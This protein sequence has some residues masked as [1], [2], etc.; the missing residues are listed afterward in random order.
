MNAL[1]E[2]KENFQWTC[3]DKVNTCCIALE[4]IKSTYKKC[5]GLTSPP[6]AVQI[7]YICLGHLAEGFVCVTRLLSVEAAG[8][9]MDDAVASCSYMMEG[10][11]Q[12]RWHQ[13]SCSQ[14]GVMVVYSAYS[15]VDTWG[16]CC[17]KL[18]CNPNTRGT[19]SLRGGPE[20]GCG[21]VS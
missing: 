2:I 21:K 9:M 18:F 5:R 8:G 11:F 1:K 3:S 20:N 7:M 10:D 4:R 13:L 15:V 17:L 12:L 16:P 6:T 14:R 19:N